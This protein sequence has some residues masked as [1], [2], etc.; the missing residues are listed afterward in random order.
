MTEIIKKL[1][2]CMVIKMRLIN[3]AKRSGEYANNFRQFPIYSEWVGM[4]QTLK[5]MG[6]EF[7]IDYD[8]TVTDMTAITI[9]GMRFEV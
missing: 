4:T 1:G 5:T 9:M 2:E 3:R 7:E 6:F 8:E